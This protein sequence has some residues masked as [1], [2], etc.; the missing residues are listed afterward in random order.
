MGA[1]SEER[2]QQVICFRTWSEK[3]IESEEN[4]GK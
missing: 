4:E 1:Q 3:G 2:S